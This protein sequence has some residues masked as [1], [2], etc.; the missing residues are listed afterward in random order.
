MKLMTTCLAAVTAALTFATAGQAETLR[1]GDFQS[2]SHIVSVEGT[3]KWMAAVEEA[4]DGAIT[5]QHFPSQQA[6][7]SKAQLDAVNNGI[8]DAALL[9]T[10]YH[11]DVLPLNSV[12]ALPGF[13]TTAEQGTK[14]LQAMLKDGPL[15]EEILAAG[16]TP[17]FG[18]V[19][20]PYQVLAKA[21]LGQP[22][23]WDA[24]DIRTSGST[25][26]M[27]AR[28]LG[29]VGISIPGPEVY[30]AVERGRLDAVL[31]PLASVPGYKLNEVVSHISTNGSF[32]GYSFVMVIRSDLFDGLP[33]E[34]QAELLRLGDESALHVAQAQDASVSELIEEW[35]AEG[36]D[37]YEF[38]DEE[39][40][41]VKD[42]L[43]AVSLD[44]VERIK[45]DNAQAVLDAYAAQTS[46]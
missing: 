28:A 45:S 1:L 31:F 12:V 6:A 29:G 3:T 46:Q 39:L 24:Q 15:R 20:P 17:I 30:T 43:S 35:K 37:T 10:P 11:A 16:V 18:F 8:L 13:Y 27:T 42:A 36:I 21:R 41:A 34:T 7:K 26:A 22:A 25:Q 32:G 40:T 33:E 9:G 38:T 5:F 44:W 19:L 14:A 23:D 4:T 2:T